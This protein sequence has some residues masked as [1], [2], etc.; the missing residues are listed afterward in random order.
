MSDASE[1]AFVRYHDGI[2]RPSP[3]EREAIEGIVESM[4]SE[5]DKVAAARRG[6]AV[7]ASHAKPS[8][9]LKGTLS[10]HEGL[11]PALRQGVFAQPATYPALVRL[12][13][14]PGEH[15]SDKIS[16]HRGLSLKLFG[17]EGDKID[18]HAQ[19]T[20]DFVLAT[21]AVFPDP[22][23]AA[24]LRSMRRIEAHAGGSETLKEVVS[25]AARAL[26][27]TVRAVTGSDVPRLDFFGHPP[28]HP[29]AESYHS[30][31][32]CRYGDYVA[33]VGLFPVTPMQLGLAGEKLDTNFD[34]DVFRHATVGYFRRNEAVFE[35]RVQLCTDTESMPI[36]NASVEWPE[37]LSPYIAVATLTLPPQDAF[38]AERVAYVEQRVGFRPA[39]ALVAHRPLGSLMRARLRA[40][41]ALAAYRQA[42]NRAIPVEPASLDEV[43]D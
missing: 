19:N 43:P 7:R 1:T 22:D 23:A 36:E 18:G 38:S 14:G 33:K 9:I 31:V 39:H 2:E 28:L 30:Q 40:Y 15:L 35:F 13:Q 24:F 25:N 29:M 20:Q 5:T 16:T 41:A 27:A 11:P 34:N 4:R 21:G 26:N 12:S 37:R 32:P 17:V 6:L 3:G 8:G 42:Y 10:V